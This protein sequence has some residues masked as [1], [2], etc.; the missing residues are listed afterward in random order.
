MCHLLC[1]LLFHS[2][3]TLNLSFHSCSCLFPLTVGES[4]LGKSTLINSLFLTDLYKDKN[5]LEASGTE[6]LSILREKD[7]PIGVTKREGRI[8]SEGF[9][10]PPEKMVQTVSITKK[11]VLIEEK[12]VKLK[13][14]IVDTPGFG[15][16]LN[17]LQWYSHILYKSSL[18]T[19]PSGLL[20]LE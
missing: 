7:G 15:D 18:F 3:P 20:D 12:G 8:L 13:L 10:F 16:A 1:H 11:T 19:S 5:V 2:S 17:N 4:G 9:S 14:N 6:L